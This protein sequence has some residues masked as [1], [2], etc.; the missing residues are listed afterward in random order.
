[1]E[2]RVSY[3]AGVDKPTGA[4]LAFSAP[5]EIE[6]SN[7]PDEYYLKIKNGSSDFM[8]SPDGDA[9]GYPSINDAK[10]AMEKVILNGVQETK[11]QVLDANGTVIPGPPFSGGAPNFTFRLVCADQVL[12]ISANDYATAM[13]A[14]NDIINIA[15]PLF[16]D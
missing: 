9:A 1:L 5:F 3:L 12:A 6:E 7:T 4:Q 15:V 10:L 2:R 13:D 16:T 14:Y 8:Y 11:F